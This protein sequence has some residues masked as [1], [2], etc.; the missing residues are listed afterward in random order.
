M[1]GEAARLRRAAAAVAIAATAALPGHGA[2]APL[3]AWT[4]E[5][6]C[7]DGRAQGPYELRG[8]NGQLRVAGAFN[9]GRRT[10]SFIFW[11]ANGVRVAHVPYD[12][13]GVRNG[14]VAVW[15]PG[16]PGREPVRRFESVFH[17]GNRDG[18]ARSWY[19]DG[20]RRSE[21]EY[22]AGRIV[23]SAAW[24]DAGA[25]LDDAAASE[26][27]Q[28]DA[29]DADTDYAELDALIRDHAPRCG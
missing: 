7:R 21:T 4:V 11:A 27:A 18:L 9:E 5:G 20:R 1:V 19:A 16:T 6:N 3:P 12:D 25:R 17:R 22:L 26:I 10:G 15:Y 14:T 8:E 28:R 29:A 2:A 13:G 23:A 24:S